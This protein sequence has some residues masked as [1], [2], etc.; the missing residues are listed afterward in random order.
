VISRNSWE[1]REQLDRDIGIDRKYIIEYMEETEKAESVYEDYCNGDIM[2]WENWVESV[3][4]EGKMV[5]D[6]SDWQIKSRVFDLA[7]AMMFDYEPK[8]RPRHQIAWRVGWRFADGDSEIRSLYGDEVGDEY[9]EKIR[10]FLNK[11]YRDANIGSY[12]GRQSFW[13]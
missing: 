8:N 11:M 1:L 13:R 3:N 6:T 10:V 7:T 2:D 12:N 5:I 4:Y 9:W